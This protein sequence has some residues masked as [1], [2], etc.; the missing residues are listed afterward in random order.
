MFEPKM[1]N[2]LTYFGKWRGDLLLTIKEIFLVMLEDG[3][4][5][6]GG[7]AKKLPHLNIGY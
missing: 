3:G 2:F 7:S 1:M 5:P 6:L 4:E